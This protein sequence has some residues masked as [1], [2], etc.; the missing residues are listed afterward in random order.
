MSTPNAPTDP[1]NRLSPAA[2][3][4]LRCPVTG[5][6]V[7]LENNWL[8]AEMG[9]LAYPIR[10]GI[11]VMLAESARLPTGFGSLDEFKVRYQRQSP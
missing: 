1:A 3:Q 6:A 5:S 8:V 10:D 7:R 4:V 2:L 9:G 11:P